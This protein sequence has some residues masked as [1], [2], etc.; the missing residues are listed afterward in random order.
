MFQAR[1]S[2]G[3]RWQNWVPQA[4]W[5]LDTRLSVCAK[6]D[7]DF[8][9]VQE[10]QLREAHLSDDINW[11]KLTATVMQQMEHQHM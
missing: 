1:S 2:A 11:D 8:R 4:I 3:F 6:P 9:Y 7:S 5:I 10:Q